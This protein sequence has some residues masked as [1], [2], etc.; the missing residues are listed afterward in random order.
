[1]SSQPPSDVS[2]NPNPVQCKR[3]RKREMDRISQ[4]RKRRRDREN[5][6]KME[7]RLRL[8]QKDSQNQ[9]LMQLMKSADQNEERNIR[10]RKRLLQ[11]RGLI[12]ADL[13]DLGHCDTTT[14]VADKPDGLH[15]DH[16][17]ADSSSHGEPE[18]LDQMLAEYND[19]ANIFGCNNDQTTDQAFNA[20]DF[21]TLIPGADTLPWDQEAHGIGPDQVKDIMIP[22]EQTTH[23]NGRP[24]KLWDE[25]EQLLARAKLPA[26][27]PS[28][29]NE[30]VDMHIIINAVSRGWSRF[31]Q[32]VRVDPRWSCLRDLDERYFS[33]G[34]APVERL[35][36]LTIASQLLDGDRMRPSVGSKLLPQFMKPRPSQQAIPHSAIADF[37]VWPGFRERLTVCHQYSSD[38]FLRAMHIMFQ[39]LWPYD[40]RATYD[41][42]PQTG[43]SQFSPQFLEH[44]GDLRCW[45][46]NSDFLVEFPDFRG[47][48][49]TF[50]GGP[51]SLLSIG[52]S[53]PEWYRF[54]TTEDEESSR[55]S[56]QLTTVL[57]Y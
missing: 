7:E 29:H 51:P 5:L 30:E 57:G 4:Q 53:Y 17:D 8:L 42:N 26:N 16:G 44:L 35:A 18:G 37:Y 54:D 36:V 46:M 11:I 33:S 24:R 40:L 14:P 27:S 1:M 23:Q 22:A 32:V 45:T 43:L 34:Y 12:Q 38:N 47:D 20:N 21:G 39:F 48:V 52:V 25:V 28:V 3:N 6:Q 2:H 19:E 49:P 41:I 55:N 31:S 15:P 56:L 10:H 50:N 9:L 13:A